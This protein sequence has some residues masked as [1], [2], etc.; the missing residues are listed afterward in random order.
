MTP[1]DQDAA[2]GDDAERRRHPRITLK[3]YGLTHICALYL[4]D[5]IREAIIVDISSGGARLRPRDGLPAPAQ[6]QTLV[7]DTR[8]S[9]VPAGDARRT[10]VVRWQAG[11]DFGMAFDQELP[12]GVFDLQ[13]LLDGGSAS[14]PG[15]GCHPSPEAL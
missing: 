9:G 1:F 5:A 2:P 7:L 10:G 6:G 15:T 11:A 14:G 12:F 13:C 4:K 8:F 3:A